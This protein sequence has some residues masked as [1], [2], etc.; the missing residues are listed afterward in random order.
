MPVQD[1]IYVNPSP[2]TVR[3]HTTVPVQDQTY[4]NPS[5]FEVVVQAQCNVNV[6][7]L[8]DIQGHGFE[9]AGDLT[10]PVDQA[11]GCFLLAPT[12]ALQ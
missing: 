1:Q 11:Q 8:T 4:T 12:I 9:L 10:A 7:V 3:R 2:R 5:L 6:V